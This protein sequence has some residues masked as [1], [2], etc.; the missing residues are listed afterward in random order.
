MSTSLLHHR[1]LVFTG[2]LGLSVSACTTDL[3]DEFNAGQQPS[4]ELEAAF[5][6]PTASELIRRAEEFSTES[7][8]GATWDAQQVE[9]YDGTAGIPTY[10]VARHESRV[11]Y[12]VNIGCSGTL[13]SDD[14]FLSAGHCGYAVG[15]T[16]RF[17]YQN[18]PDGSARTPRD[19]A[20]TQVVEQENTATWD[21]AIV[22]LANS[23]GREFGHANIAAIDPPAG[24]VV[25]IIGHPAGR[26][27]EIHAGAVL[28]Y[29]SSVG[30]NWF[31]HQ[32]DTVGG[33][34]GSGVLNSDGQVI[35]VHTNAGCVTSTPVGGNS[36][37][38]MSQLVPHSATLQ[39][40]TRSKILWRHNS[41]QI[42]LWSLNSAGGYLSSVAHGPFAGWTPMSYSNNR[43][44]WRHDDGRISYWTLND[45][46]QQLT[47]AESGPYAGWTAVN[48]ANDRV[49]WRHSSGQISLWTV[50]SVGNYVSSQ[51]YGPYPGWTAVNYANNRILWRHDDG[52][53][54]FW[55]VDDA[56]SFVSSIV[57]GPFPG[58]TAMSYENGELL[59]RH[60]DGRTS[61]W[62][63]N[64]AGVQLTYLENGPYPGWTPIFTS[65]RKLL[66]RHSSGQIS[67][68]NVNSYGGF[69][70]YVEHGPISGWTALFTSG[71]R[72]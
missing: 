69:L 12:H 43:L 33:N 9:R 24:S 71:A 6:T 26:A 30:T 21:Y 55:R 64:R 47:Y 1:L 16:V 10:F 62:T 63:M 61:T 52:R 11:G 45:A 8:C 14:L 48:H 49:L 39:A 2:L 44:L 7:Q 51:A 36:A 50:N 35:G 28:D 38:R 29:S 66:W 56:N 25:T 40:L 31:R 70:N 41:G 32:V 17:D 67:F 54:S 57:Y 23:P 18:A 53:I 59:W 3:D 46:N 27:K 20:V 68:W 60:V 58:Y 65:D 4:D 22:R 5:T 72:P 37:L 15:H 34:S 13:I 19:F 42:S